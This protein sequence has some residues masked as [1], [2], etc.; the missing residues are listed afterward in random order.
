ML[1]AKFNTEK[2]S[3]KIGLVFSK[4]GMSPNMWTILALIPAF[5]GFLLLLEGNLLVAAAFFVFS[6]FLDA[7]DGAVARVTGSVTNLG[8]FL[9]GIVDRYVEILLY[10]GLLFFLT[11]S[12]IE[13][14]F[15]PHQYWISLL[16]FGALMPTFVRAYADHRN[17]VTEPEDHRKMGGLIER[18]ERLILLFVGMIL[19]YFNPVY[20]AYIV[21]LATVLTNLT[22]L[23]R[24]IFV[25]RFK[26]T[27]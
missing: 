4:L 16:I 6:G 1:K 10:L 22:A 25:L 20:L 21:V 26:K 9:D 17:V 7:I 11:N 12:T 27:T 5:F 8:A 14:I 18:A 23:H 3:I 2:I 24:I 13:E 19:G 15:V